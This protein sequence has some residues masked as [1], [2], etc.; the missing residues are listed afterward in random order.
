MEVLTDSS[1]ILEPEGEA[2]AVVAKCFWDVVSPF[3]SDSKSLSEKPGADTKSEE[4]SQKSNKQSSFSA[5]AAIL[6]LLLSVLLGFLLLS[7]RAS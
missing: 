2:P 5:V 6:V 7:A 4:S 1:N 3:H